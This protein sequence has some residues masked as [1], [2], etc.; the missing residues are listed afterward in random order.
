MSKISWDK[1]ILNLLF[2]KQIDSFSVDYSCFNYN[3][4]TNIFNYEAY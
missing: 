1:K 3:D 2:D 4:W